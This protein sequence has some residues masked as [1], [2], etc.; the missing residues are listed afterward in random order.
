VT[1]FDIKTG[2]K[3]QSPQEADKAARPEITYTKAFVNS[4]MKVAK[5]DAKIVAITAAMPSGT[6]LTAFQKEFPKRFFDVGIA[7]QYAVTFAGALSKGGMKPVCAIYS[8]FLQRSQDSLIHDVALQRQHLVL[9]MDRAGLV[10]ADG[11][12]HN[13]VFDISYLGH[14]PKSVIAA[15]KDQFEMDHMMRLAVDYAHIFAMRYPRANIPK[16]YDEFPHDVFEIGQGEVLCEGDDGTLLAMGSMVETALKA[17][18]L[19]KEKGIDARVVNMRFAKPLDGKLIVQSLASNRHLFTV[20]EH[21]RTGG[22]GSK[23]LEFLESAEITDAQVH[24]LALPD[25]FIEHGSRDTL[26]DQFGL[27]PEKIAKSFALVVSKSGQPRQRTP[28]CP[29]V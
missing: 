10:G 11:A 29:V 19:L 6:G 25:E 7:E 8:T 17:A 5:E 15:P 23:V 3:V 2:E 27:S 22:F 13:G 21:C 18:A 12:T 9:C 16:M 1:P 28:D 24:R 14:V 26:L 4:L 20:E